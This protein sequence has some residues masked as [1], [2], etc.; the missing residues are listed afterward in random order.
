MLDFG[1]RSE[2]I[3]LGFRINFSGLGLYF[4]RLGYSFPVLG[5]ILGLC[6]GLFSLPLSFIFLPFI[7]L[8]LITSLAGSLRSFKKREGIW[9]SQRLLGRFWSRGRRKGNGT[10]DFADIRMVVYTPGLHLNKACRDSCIAK[11]P[12][13]CHVVIILTH[14]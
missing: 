2:K 11:G 10:G 13:P 4:L 14:L 1:W 7:P 5:S 8:A 12:I 9:D 3:F 6:E